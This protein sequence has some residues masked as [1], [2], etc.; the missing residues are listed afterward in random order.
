MHDTDSLCC[1]KQTEKVIDVVLTRAGC[2][3]GYIEV[4]DGYRVDDN[5]SYIGR[6]IDG[7]TETNDYHV[8]E[9]YLLLND[10]FANI[11]ED[12][13]VRHSNSLRYEASHAF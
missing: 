8:F 6:H 7:C 10:C 5:Q 13:V 1:T 11:G 3:D 4:V 12:V 2:N 9:V